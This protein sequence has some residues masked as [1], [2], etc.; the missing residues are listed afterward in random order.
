MTTRA[1]AETAR[2][3]RRKEARCRHEN[4]GKPPQHPRHRGLT[5]E[6]QYE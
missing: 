5:K 1:E 4:C 2:M 6:H 3:K